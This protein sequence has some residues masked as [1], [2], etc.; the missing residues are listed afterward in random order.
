SVRGM[1]P[2]I[3]RLLGEDR[4]LVVE[5]GDTPLVSVD[6]DQ[7]TR[8]I[9]NLALNARYATAAGGALFVS[10]A[11]AELPAALAAAGGLTI[12]AGRYSTLIVRDNGS[13]MDPKTKARIFEPFFT[14]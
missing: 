13:G 14:T 6:P 3:R 9:V 4:Q 2:A 12:P 8:V 5:A 1:M 11:V 7:L 10:T